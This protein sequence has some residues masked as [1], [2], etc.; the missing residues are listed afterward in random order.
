MDLPSRIL[1]ELT[2]CIEWVIKGYY[3]VDIDQDEKVQII[4]PVTKGVF[5]YK[6]TI[7]DFF[8][9]VEEV[10]FKKCVF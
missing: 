8:S 10:Y 4:H 2:K 5:C 1:N 7:E 9:V 3:I 6:F